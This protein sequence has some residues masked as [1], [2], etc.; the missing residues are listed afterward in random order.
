MSK[1]SKV[2]K[3]SIAPADGRHSSDKPPDNVPDLQDAIRRLQVQQSTH[4]NNI[5]SLHR[6]MADTNAK[7]VALTAK[8]NASNARLDLLITRL[9]AKAS[10]QPSS[11]SS[12]RP[13]LAHDESPRAPSKCIQAKH[14]KVRL[15]EVDADAPSPQDPHT[16]KDVLPALAI[17]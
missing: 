9:E 15:P 8:F 6:E 12:P 10:L 3:S 13:R 17:V 11:T 14:P 5:R 7:L 16:A 1:K 4:A 2:E